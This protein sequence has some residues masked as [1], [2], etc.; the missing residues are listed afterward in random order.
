[1]VARLSSLSSVKLRVTG[2]FLPLHRVIRLTIG[3][4]SVR[5]FWR[6]DSSPTSSISTNTFGVQK[7]SMPMAIGITPTILAGSG[8][9]GLQR[10]VVL[11]TGRR[12]D[13]DIGPGARHMAGPGSD[14]KHGVGRLIT[15]AVGFITMATGPGVHVAGFTETEVGGVQRLLRSCS[16][17]LLATTF[18]G[19]HCR[20]TKGIRIRVAIVAIM[21]DATDAITATTVP[22][23]AAM[24]VEMAGVTMNHGV[25]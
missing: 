1:M 20:T 16:T 3:L 6:S 13:T 21:M 17:F 12:I 14:M 8:D 11:A 4:A 15:T 23:P 5:S 19:I 9:R 25:A 10:S 7:I 22:G 24:G 2:N 18:A